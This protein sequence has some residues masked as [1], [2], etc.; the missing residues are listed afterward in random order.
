MARRW[1]MEASEMA[2]HEHAFMCQL[3]ETPTHVFLWLKHEL[4]CRTGIAGHWRMEASEGALAG[5]R[6]PSPTTI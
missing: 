5:G 6:S 2:L 1:R 4:R 3:Y